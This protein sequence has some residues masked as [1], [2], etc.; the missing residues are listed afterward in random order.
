MRTFI[1][2]CIS[3]VLIMIL[4]WNN[5]YCQ[6]EG[7]INKINLDLKSYKTSD[8]RQEPD[9]LQPLFA[10]DNA[11]APDKAAHLVVSAILVGVGYNIA[12]EFDIVENRD[13]RRKAVGVSVFAVGFGK[14][15][16]DALSKNGD[17][18]YKDILANI[19][20]IGI[21]LVIFAQ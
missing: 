20:G 6:E 12:T 3:L 16:Y 1:F 9:T 21:G 18:S 17:A 15:F 13:Q 7:P 19:L 8:F 5:V 10:R 14:E 11:F 2:F 4:S